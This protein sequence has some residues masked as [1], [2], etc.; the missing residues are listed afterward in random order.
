MK[1]FSISLQKN[2]TMFIKNAL[3]LNCRAFYFDVVAVL[4][5]QL[6]IYY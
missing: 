4:Y 1:K 3:Q 5:I 2:N 6:V